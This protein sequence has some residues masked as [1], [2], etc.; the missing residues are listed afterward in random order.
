MNL[1]LE[2]TSSGLSKHDAGNISNGIGKRD[3]AY[4]IIQY[5]EVNKADVKMP[6]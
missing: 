1:K 6:P 4:N 3:V 5:S 2:L